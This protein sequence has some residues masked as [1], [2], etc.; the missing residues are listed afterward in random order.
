MLPCDDYGYLLFSQVRNRGMRDVG[1][2]VRRDTLLM[3]E[4]HGHCNSSCV[5]LVLFKF[6]EVGEYRF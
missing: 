3:S 6:I 4:L 2:P 1:N 5:M